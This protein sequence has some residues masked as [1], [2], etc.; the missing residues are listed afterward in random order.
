MPKTTKTIKMTKNGTIDRRFKR[1]PS[2]EK[3]NIFVRNKRIPVIQKN[4]GKT[5]IFN[6]IRHW[7]KKLIQ[8]IRKI[9]AFVLFY[10]VISFVFVEYVQR[11][12]IF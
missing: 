9:S 12:G 4:I 5:I 8:A 6:R 7:L 10:S 1:K 2:I 3:I 11:N